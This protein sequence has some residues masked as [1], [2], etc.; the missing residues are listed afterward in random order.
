M[1]IIR[2][3]H[4]LG[5]QPHSTQACVATVGNFDGVHLGHAAIIQQLK[6]HGAR[7][8]VPSCVMVFEPQ[9]R[10]FFAPQTAP[11]RLTTLREKAEILAEMGVDQLL[12]VRFDRKF[13]ALSAAE[14]CER[15]LVGGLGVQHLVVGDDFRFGHDRVGDFHF[16]EQAG[17]TF[18]FGVEATRTFA[19]EGERVSSTRIRE[20]LAA[21]DFAAAQHLLGRP[22]GFSGR[23]AH[24]DKLGR[25]LGVPTANLWPNRLKSPLHGVY[26]VWADLGDGA[27]RP[28]V[29]S[30]GARPT[31]GGTRWRLETHLLDFQG[32]LY[33]RRMRVEF[34]T[35]IRD[36]KKFSGL[37]ELKANIDNDI[38]IAREIFSGISAA[39]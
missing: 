25:T 33:G 8:G 6:E 15:V 22:F 11:A 2:G 26:A 4:N 16:L 27:R 1:E 29:A 3:L 39:C 5:P 17:A 14:F 30:I 28:A 20:A 32:D 35:R 34:I 31:V 19:L 10:E 24:G 9:P 21:G 7:L 23:V 36:E 38:Q 18:G 12:C 37:E 13:C